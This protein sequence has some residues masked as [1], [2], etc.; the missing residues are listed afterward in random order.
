MSLDGRT[1][2]SQALISSVSKTDVAV[3]TGRKRDALV[4]VIAGLIDRLSSDIPLPHHWTGAWGQ[5]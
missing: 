3:A 5:P 2:P 4:R 1:D